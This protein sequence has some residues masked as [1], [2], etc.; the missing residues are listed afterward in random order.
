MNY[1]ISVKITNYEYFPLS[2]LIDSN[3]SWQR[4]E[5]GVVKQGKVITYSEQKLIHVMWLWLEKEE[6]LKNRVGN[7]NGFSYYWGH[8]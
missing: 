6:T 2:C 4:G 7:A 3:F 1:K 5:K 8:S